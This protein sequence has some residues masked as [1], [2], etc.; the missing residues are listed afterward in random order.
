MSLTLL[1]FK[2]Q[3]DSTNQFRFHTIVIDAGH[4]GKDPGAHG[5]FSTEKKVALAIALKLQKALEA[6]LPEINTVMTRSTDVFIPLNERARIANTHKGNLFISIHCNSS[7]LAHGKDKGSL[8]LV[9]GYHRSGEQREAIREN[10]SIFIEKNYK[11]NYSDYDPNSPAAAIILNNYMLRY[12][13]QS[14]LFST[15]LNEEIKD[16]YNRHTFGVKEQGILVLAHS[17]MPAVLVETG[18]INNEDDEEYLNS[19]EGQMQ[20]VNSIVKAVKA[21]KER[22]TN[23]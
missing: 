6:Q 18:F 4:G 10:A 12:R 1:S 16:T 5:A 21:Y 9:Y 7:P 8:F 17:A 19:E 3:S 2:P 22:I 15:L 11:E 13:K 23:N 20:I 14:I